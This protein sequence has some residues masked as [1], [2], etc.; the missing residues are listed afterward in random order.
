MTGVSRHSFPDAQCNICDLEFINILLY[1]LY[2]KCHASLSAIINAKRH[3]PPAREFH[4]SCKMSHSNGLISL[5]NVL[6]MNIS[7]MTGVSHHSFADAQCNISCDLEFINI[8]LYTLY[9]KCHTS[10]SA[11][12]NAKRHSSPAREFHASCKMSHS[13]GLI[14]LMS[15][16]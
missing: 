6:L 16:L 7:F 4:A 2:Y 9:Y 14:S 10:L 15:Y 3:S 13:N 1:T 5:M 12:I 11:I 8:L